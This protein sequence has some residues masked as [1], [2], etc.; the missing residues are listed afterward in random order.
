MLFSI[1]KFG[2]TFKIV[3]TKYKLKFAFILDIGYIIKV[4][5][6]LTV[7]GVYMWTRVRDFYLI[8]VVTVYAYPRSMV[9]LYSN[10]VYLYACESP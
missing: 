4:L 5:S 10:V 3:L 2:K 7:S 6:I 1:N 8:S 9:M